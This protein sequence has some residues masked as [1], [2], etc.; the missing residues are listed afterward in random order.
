[1][2]RSMTGYGA[3]ERMDDQVRVA[4]EIRAVN[5]KFFKAN[6]R[7]PDGLGAVE[8]ALEKILRDGI[9]RG[10]VSV[11]VA[12]EPRGDAARAPVNTEILA[13]YWRDLSALA[14]R[15]GDPEPV[16]IEAL[17]GL[18]GVVGGEQAALTG[19]ENL[20]GKIEA[21][22]KE[23]LD[24]F[25]AMRDTEGRATADD[26]RRSL[27]DIERRIKNIEGRVPAVIAEY[28]ERLRQRVREILEG[29]DVAADDHIL[30]REVAFAAERSDVGE[31]LARLASHVAQYRELLDES[32]PAGRKLEFLTQEMYR[33][34]NTLGSKANDAA[35]SREVVDMKVG[36]D[37]LREQSLNVE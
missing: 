3:A 19:I 8:V 10:T 30:A 37:R 22:V 15:V 12:V 36:V 21:A 16:R 35:I 11:N 20:P 13:A 7:L 4:A 2:I 14:K 5:N 17:V 34:V 26:M 9:S 18:P 25:N 23:A 6:L 24:R 28:R 29:A 33:E 32:G 31:E 27:D 1:M